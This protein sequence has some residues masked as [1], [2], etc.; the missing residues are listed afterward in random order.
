MS[1]PR[2]IGLTGGIGSGK[3]TVAGMFAAL[4]VPVLDLDGVGRNLLLP[5]SE[6][7]QRIAETFGSAFLL[8]DGSLD[9]PALAMHC[10]ADA[11]RTQSL[12]AIM[13]PLIWQHEQQW[14]KQ[15]S[16][17]Y[18]VIEASVLLE[19]DAYR[20]MHAV[21]VV[22]A[23]EQ[24]RLQRV[25]SRGDRNRQQFDDIVSRQCSDEK[26]RAQADYL[27]ENNDSLALLEQQVKALHQLLLQS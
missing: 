4:A 11:Q 16:A 19:S 3:S 17:P 5:C 8:P 24:L 21:V 9:R 27:I 25:L 12:N 2:S 22:L 14:V 10:F 18:V 15:Q 20:R 13:H 6:A 23:D 1:P 26:R 7:L